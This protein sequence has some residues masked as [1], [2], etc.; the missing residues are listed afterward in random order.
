MHWEVTKR[1]MARA[2]WGGVGL[3]GSGHPAPLDGRPRKAETLLQACCISTPSSVR[4]S[5]CPKQ[6]YWINKVTDLFKE[7]ILNHSGATSHRNSRCESL[8]WDF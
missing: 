8:T 5:R 7:I 1:G 2:T 4:Q 6:I 3:L